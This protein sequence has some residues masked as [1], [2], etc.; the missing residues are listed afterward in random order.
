[1]VPLMLSNSI[2]DERGAGGGGATLETG[3][4]N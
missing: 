4:F 3:K 2:L 1:M